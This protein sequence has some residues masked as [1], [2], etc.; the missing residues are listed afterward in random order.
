MSSANCARIA[1]NVESRSA[2]GEETLREFFLTVPLIQ[3]F[4]MAR[5]FGR[6]P[7]SVSMQKVATTLAIL[8]SG[9]VSLVSHRTFPLKC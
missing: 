7:A 9:E 6:N 2:T 8:K 3:I 5:E 1:L 4:L